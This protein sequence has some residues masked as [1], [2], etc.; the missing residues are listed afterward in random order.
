MLELRSPPADTELSAPPSSVFG[1]DHRALLPFFTGVEA[2]G[3]YLAFSQ[4]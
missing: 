1:E 4:C 3:I 2:G